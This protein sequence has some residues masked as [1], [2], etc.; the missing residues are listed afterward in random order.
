M[1][2]EATAAVAPEQPQ[3]E[4]ASGKPAP[5]TTTGLHSPPD[6]NSAMKLDDTDDESELS[7]IEDPA[8]SS[9][10]S[11]SFHSAQSALD[12]N[13]L[14]AAVDGDEPEE[15]IKQE[16]DDDDD[17]GEILPDHWSGTV[18]VFKPDM[19]QFKDFKKFVCSAQSCPGR[20][21]AH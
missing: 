1:S 9:P 8:P 16:A 19:R 4:V 7:E 12:Q 20:M 18:P 21:A 2:A 11:Q 5:T 3:I 14:A 15:H 17:I 10:G 13:P 6:S